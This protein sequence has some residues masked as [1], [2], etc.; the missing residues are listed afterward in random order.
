MTR[1]AQI[2]LENEQLLELRRWAEEAGISQ[3]QLMLRIVDDAIRRRKIGGSQGTG[4]VDLPEHL[5][6]LIKQMAT[7]PQNDAERD[8]IDM[9]LRYADRKRGKQ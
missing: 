9:L 6:L 4:H 8:L 2:R 5:L 1:H 7:E 3:Q